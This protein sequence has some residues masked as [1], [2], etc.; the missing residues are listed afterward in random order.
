[1]QIKVDENKLKEI[2][3]KA[4]LNYVPIIAE[5]SLEYITNLLKEVKP[6]KILEIGTA[7]GYSASNFCRYLNIDE[8]NN[9]SYITTIERNEKRFKEAS[10]NIKELQL[11][12]YINILY[13]D[14]LDI[15]P[16]LKDN[17]YDIVFIDAAKGQYIK[18]LEEAKRLVKNKG[19][20]IADN[21]LFHGLTLSDSNEHRN[22]TA[23]TRLRKFLELIEED[24]MLTSKLIKVGDGLTISYINKIKKKEI[25]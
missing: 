21:V 7:V 1:M 5:D 24:E 14:A 11:E 20:I 10:K 9:E 19:I 3:E 6:N 2:K 16:S 22:R 13:G 8:K 23:V 17:T 12:E 15:L 18:F 25:F 4:I